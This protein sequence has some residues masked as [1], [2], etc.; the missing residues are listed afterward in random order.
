MSA[1][2]PLPIT[3]PPGLVA[4]ESGRS[5]QG[6]WTLPWNWFR[7]KHGKPQKMGGWVQAFA[8]ATSGIPHCILAWTDLM[9][10]RFL[11]A[12]TYRK[13]YVYDQNL[14]QN[15]ITPIR[16]S[17]GGIGGGTNLTNP[18]TTTSGSSIVYVTQTAHGVLLGDQVIYTAVGSA[19]GGITAAQLT[20]AFLCVPSVSP[21]VDDAN[22]FSFDC[23][24]V[25][26][27]SAGP[28]GGTVSYMYEINVGTE[29][30]VLGLGW[31]VGG[32]GLGTWG[33]PRA[34]STILFE[35]RVWALDHFG[36][37]L[38]GTFN[39][40]TIYTFDPTQAQPWG[41]IIQSQPRAIANTAAIA[42]GITDC[43]SVF[44]TPERFVVALRENLV[45]SACN[46]GDFN[47]W[48]PA[49]S[50]TAWSRTLTDGSKLMGGS[51][52]APFQSL[53]WTD[54]SVHMFQ[55]TG[56]AF[57]YRSSLIGKDCGLIGTNA[58]ICTNGVAFWMTPSNFMMYDGSVHPMPNVED[59]RKYVFDNI[60][61]SQTIEI[62]AGYEPINDE[63]WFHV[64]LFGS[65][66]PNYLIVF[67][68]E[69][70]CWTIHPNVTR[71]SMTNFV[72]GD[73]RPYLGDVSGLIYQHEIGNDAAGAAI[74]SQMTL[75][76]YAMAESLQSMDLEG[77][78]LDP[79]QQTGNITAVFNTY[80][81]LSDT[82]VLDTETETV[83]VP[84]GLTDTRIS[85]RYIGF[86][87]SQNSIGAYFR[88]GSPLA[89]V[90]PTG[91]RR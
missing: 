12:G 36:K 87:L 66:T 49:T 57:I 9:V 91:K 62:S 4:T 22:H 86:T 64:P 71:V 52:L 13:F 39:G 74:S 7:F 77:I 67:H 79:F 38:V 51:A 23:G 89:M 2:T 30:A 53:V 82:S 75:G 61:I 37:I 17:S 83:T 55:W 73:N 90:R 80:D 47:T 54:G 14:V 25:A 65:A 42:A 35:A 6:R 18:F 45:I 46:Q 10:N 1:L 20:G 58:N 78:R 32:W 28:G 3:P 68:K 11:A 44:V 41:G 84:S 85:G 19:V 43:R 81:E 15:D 31:G 16:L 76:P 33:T 24:T 59:I 60:N 34:S 69:D 56:D 88:Y 26:G 50:N 8:A 27:S 48:V 72:N 29:N 70:Q 5:V 40:G 63:I 21:N